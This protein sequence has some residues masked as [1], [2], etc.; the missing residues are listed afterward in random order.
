MT[1][2]SFAMTAAETAA[3]VVVAAVRA[4][5]AELVVGAV[6]APSE[7]IPLR[8]QELIAHPV[9]Q[10][11]VGETVVPVVLVEMEATP[12]RKDL[13]PQFA[14]AK[15]VKGATVVLAAVVVPEV[16]ASPEITAGEPI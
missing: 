12:E 14:A 9:S 6:E 3:E 5:R 10:R 2:H 4:E 7:F 11:V 1:S 8:V 16:P 13:V 15:L